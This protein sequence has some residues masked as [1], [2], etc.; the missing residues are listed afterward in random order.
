MFRPLVTPYDPSQSRLI[1]VLRGRGAPPMP[2]DRPL[3]E[4]DIRL[5][6]D[7]ILNGARKDDGVLTDGPPGQADAGATGEADADAASDG[8]A[9][10][11]DASDATDAGVDSEAG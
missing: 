4:A 1:D 10:N 3:D 2:P 8:D 7:W 9:A 6:E 11:G 5:V